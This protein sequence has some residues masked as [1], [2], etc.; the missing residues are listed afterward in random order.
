MGNNTNIELLEAEVDQDEQ[1]FF[2]I[3]DTGGPSFVRAIRTKFPSV[4]NC[5]HDTYVDYTDLILGDELRVGIYEAMFARFEWEIQYMENETT[6][7]ERIEGH[8]IGPRILGHLTEGERVIGFLMER[9]TNACHANQNDL[10]SCQQS[11]ERLHNLGVNHGDTNR[12]NFL[13]RGSKG[14]LINEM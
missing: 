12:F 6:A 5:W 14:F 9:I 10:A 11:L 2:R 7:Y 13:S 1:S 8:D 4:Q 3:R